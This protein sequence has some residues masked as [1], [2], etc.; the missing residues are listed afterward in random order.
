MKLVHVIGLHIKDNHEEAI[1]GAQLTAQLLR[2][3]TT[4][5]RLRAQSDV[6]DI[7][8]LSCLQLAEC[9]DNWESEFDRVIEEF[10]QTTGRPVL[11]A[12]LFY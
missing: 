7:F 12:V 6:T 10:Q 9:E 8:D 5:S 1:K 3:V 11:H 4:E 2:M